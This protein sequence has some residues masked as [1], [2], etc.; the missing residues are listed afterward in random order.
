MSKN[1]EKPIR[2]RLSC[3]G[4]WCNEDLIE[5]TNIEEDFDGADVVTFICPEC[6]KTHQSRRYG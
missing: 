1:Y 4:E 5:C 3:N 2:V 6:K